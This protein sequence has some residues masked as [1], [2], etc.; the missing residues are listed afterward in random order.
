MSRVVVIYNNVK[1]RQPIPITRPTLERFAAYAPLLRS[2]LKSG[3]LTGGAHGRELEERAAKYLKVKHCVAVS[4]CTAGLMLVL[5][6]LGL[7]GEVIM[8]SF[9]FCA[10][11]LPV[12]WNNLKP[13]FADIDPHTYTLDPAAVKKL[14][15]KKTSAILATHV[16]G[17]VCDVRALERIARKHNLKLVYDAAH[18][19]G[20]SL[21]ARKAGSFG[22]AEVFSMSPT[23]V[24]TAGEG[25]IVATNDTALAEFVRRGRNY[26]DDG[27]NNI[28]F[29]GLSARMPELSAAVGL[30]SFA[31]L[32]QNLKRRR[33]HAKALALGLA[34][35]E[36]LLRFQKVPKGSST[37]YKD[38]SI[39]IDA[40]LLG[41]TRDTLH[42]F[43][44]SH[45]VATRKYFYPPL[46]RQRAYKGLRSGAL[47][48]TG[49]V[50]RNVLSLPMYAHLTKQDIGRIIRVFKQ[51]YDERGT[52]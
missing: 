14:I 42:D 46:H 7:K 29:A 43:F 49:E 41:Y 28:M 2:T 27:S 12:L 38:F 20:S 18:A 10:S 9:T 32:G 40:K 36:P 39:Y 1:K 26:G 37:T 30:R 5:K 21:G 24:L 15:T 31:K 11:G 23:K 22:H 33:A 16:F 51:F 4:S 3:M 6:G 25:G 17:A 44:G 50:S 48:V 47:P 35:V 52:R 19:F 45:G 8:P 34:K 13:V